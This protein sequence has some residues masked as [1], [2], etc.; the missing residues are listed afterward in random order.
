MRN[1]SPPLIELDKDHKLHHFHPEKNLS[2]YNFLALVYNTQ[3]ITSDEENLHALLTN[4]TGDGLFE[5]NWLVCWACKK[6]S[7]DYFLPRFQNESSCNLS[8]ENKFDLNENATVIKAHFHISDF[9]RRIVLTHGDKR[10]L[11]N[12][13]LKL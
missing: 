7:S 3:L 1:S 2:T 6:A 13:V 12:G 4:I 5:N 10:Q 11:R 9:T 8:N